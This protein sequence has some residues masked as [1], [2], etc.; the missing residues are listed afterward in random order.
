M[1][2]QEIAELIQESAT[3]R[4]FRSESA[5]LILAFFVRLFRE[6]NLLVISEAEL[7]EHLADFLEDEQLHEGETG[8][9]RQISYY[10]ARARQLITRWCDQGFLRN[11]PDQRGEALYELTPESEKALQWLETLN[12]REFVGTESRFKDIL[13]RMRELVENSNQ[14]PDVRIRDLEAKQR[15][16]S[17]EIA[18]IRNEQS[19]RSFDDYQIK[20]RYLEIQRLA[21]QLL[22]DFREVEENF[23]DLTREIYQRH[24]EL[25][26]GKGQILRYAFDA[27]EALKSSDQ[28]KSFYAFWDFLLMTAGQR[29]L[30]E[31]TDQ[32]QILVRDRGL[33]LEDGLLRHLRSFLHQAAQK[34]LDSNDRMAERLSRIII[35][36]D[37][38]ESRALKESIGR[39]KELAVKL[40]DKRD[41]DSDGPFFWL[42]LHPQIAMP[43]ERRLALEPEEPVF[44]DQP[45]CE[46]DFE[47][48]EVLEYLF[49]A[50]YVD[51][52]AIRNRVEDLLDQHPD[53]SLKDVLARYPIQ[54]GLPELFAYLSLA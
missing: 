34:V 23:R 5:A 49:K 18:R 31:L 47:E 21:Q 19:V 6:R 24:L 28:G 29:E 40:A 38:Q 20:S 13:S 26:S 32:V 41:E 45:D 17:R 4:L 36:K 53:W 12:K 43:M 39:I 42:E 27:L 50:F 33:E 25:R 37:P 2:Y 10:E 1:K 51:K 9:D 15:Q 16:I 35:D 54:Q 48:P 14:D 30:Q 11:Y 52:D 46:A 22:S 8:D 3:V 44:L 7:V